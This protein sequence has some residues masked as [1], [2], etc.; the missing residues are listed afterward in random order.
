MPGLVPPRPESTA[1]N[2]VLQGHLHGIVGADPGHTTP[3]ASLAAND[4]KLKTESFEAGIPAL[5]RKRVLFG[6]K[7]NS[8]L[9]AYELSRRK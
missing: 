5:K 7:E 8:S 1:W 4:L 9:L 6:G 3:S 2:T